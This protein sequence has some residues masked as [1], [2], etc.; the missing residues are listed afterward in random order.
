M[1]VDLKTRVSN[2]QAITATATSTDYANV[3]GNQIGEGERLCF[4]VVCS[5]TPGTDD[6]AA[7]GAAT[8]TIE[9]QASSDGS[10]FNTI[11]S[12]GPIAKADLTVGKVFKAPIAGKIPSGA[13]PSLR[14]NYVV[15]T[16]PFTAGKLTAWIGAQ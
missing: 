7:A 5:G 13:K 8:L 14:L 15:A 9:V 10:T 12:I 16:G 6:F 11:S 1:V 3:Q 2:A 4:N